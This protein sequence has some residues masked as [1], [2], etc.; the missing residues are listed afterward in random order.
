VEIPGALLHEIRH[1]ESARGIIDA[2]RDLNLT[3]PLVVRMTGT[4]EEE[5]R[6]M[7]AEAGIAPEAT[8][9]GAA[10]KIVELARG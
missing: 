10:R 4:R 8:A 6:Q 7:L 2:T 9:T 3:L 5:G 1:L